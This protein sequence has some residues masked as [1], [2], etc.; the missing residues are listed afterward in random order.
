MHNAI[1]HTVKDTEAMTTLRSERTT[2]A[3]DPEA[4]E[5]FL[6][7]QKHP[8]ITRMLRQFRASWRRALAAA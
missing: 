4:V 7:R 8:L 3:S 2:K 6:K 1:R 5:A